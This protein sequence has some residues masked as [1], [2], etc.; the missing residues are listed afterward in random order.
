MAEVLDYRFRLRRARA[1]TWAS[2]NDVLLDGELGLERDTGRV[3]IGDGTTPW[4]SLPY[5]GDG[6]GVQTIVSAATVTPSTSD[7]IVIV[8]AQAVALTIVNPSGVEA[9]GQGFVLRVKDNGVMQSLS[10][11]PAYRAVGGILPS[12]TTP[13][14][15]Q[16]FPCSYN[17]TDDVWDVFFDQVG[18]S[19]APKVRAYTST[20]TAS[21]AYDDDM[22]VVSSQ[23]GPLAVANPIGAPS[24]GAGFVLSVKDDGT[25]RAL[26]WGSEY[27]GMG[28]SLPG[29]TTSGKWMYFPISYNEIDN[30]WDVFPPTVQQ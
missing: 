26:S 10:W 22:V 30:V 1:A 21:P 5:W 14:R 25:S 19:T 11:G 13:G 8:S 20:T 23:A 9:E 3:K 18:G 12:T 15:W 6:I 29:A 24:W 27:R 28:A 2:L 17:S 16:Y 4:N 7:D